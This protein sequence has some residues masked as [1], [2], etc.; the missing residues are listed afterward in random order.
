VVIYTLL[1]FT[2]KTK[3]IK[4]HLTGVILIP[5]L[6]QKNSVQ[7]IIWNNQGKVDVNTIPIQNATYE[8]S[9]KE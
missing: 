1:L 2:V 7:K 6:L 4:Q 3:V 9:Q 5:G 8:I